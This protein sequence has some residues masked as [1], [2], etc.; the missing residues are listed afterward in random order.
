MKY[1]DHL[2][3]HAYSFLTETKFPQLLQTDGKQ[4]IAT[5]TEA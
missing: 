1:T 3:N 5:L 2:Q 4:Q